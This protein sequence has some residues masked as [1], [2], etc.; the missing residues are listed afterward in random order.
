MMIRDLANI[1]QLTSTGMRVG[2]LVGMNRKDLN[3]HERQ[4]IF[5]EK[6]KKSVKCISMPESRFTHTNS[7][8]PPPLWQ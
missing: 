6:A 8:V 5:S 2:E 7:V 4:C 1:G 3:F